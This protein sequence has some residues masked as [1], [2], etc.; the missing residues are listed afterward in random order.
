MRFVWLAIKDEA[1]PDSRRGYVDSGPSGVM[2]L[3]G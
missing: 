2:F 1:G 3:G